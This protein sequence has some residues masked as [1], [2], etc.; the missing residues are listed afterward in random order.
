[1]KRNRLS[2]QA[3]RLVWLLFALVFL[4]AFLLNA[5]AL[6]GYAATICAPEEECEWYRLTVDA[7]RS[8][9][10]AGMALSTYGIV[11]AVP[12]L[13]TAVVF[14]AVGGLLF[15]RRSDQGFGLL[16]SYLLIGF[17]AAGPSWAL[18]WANPDI[19][20]PILSLAGL[21]SAPTF[22]ILQIVLLTFPNGRFQP[23]RSWLLIGLMVLNNFFWMVDDLRVNIGSWQPGLLEVWLLV[24]FG[25]PILIQIY[26]YFRLYNHM[27]RLQT[28]WFIGG[29]IG[30]LLPG[31]VLR[32]VILGLPDTLEV[33]VLR[34][35]LNAW[36]VSLFY[37]PISIAIGI[38]V[39][40]YRLWDIDIIIRRTLIYTVLTGILAAVYFG[41][42]ILTQQVFRAAT[43]ESSDL[44]IV[45]ST[46]LIAALF[47]PVRRR[48]QDGIDRRL[49][50]RKYDVEQTLADFQKNLREDVDMET[51]KAN[52]VGV[53]NDTMQPSSVRLWVAPTDSP[54]G[55]TPL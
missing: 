5:T 54:R 40:R 51:L 34:I 52:L 26:R 19:P 1:M 14:W 13:F 21:G 45:V 53:V 43:G 11:T 32:L 29:L 36:L 42:I 38:A 8:L 55:A 28:R 33:Q 16:V 12:I 27:E 15:V 48:V 6:P 25:A 24:V 17:G 10:A 20:P 31:T 9:A 50:R 41:G 39:L 18:V 47:T 4:I 3:F 46:L 23:R 37:L 30:G 22:I 7:A 49:Y 44:A 35:L 2:M